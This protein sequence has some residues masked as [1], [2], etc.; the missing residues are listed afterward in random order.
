MTKALH[1][2][3]VLELGSLIGGPFCG[4]LMAEFGAEVIKVEDPETG[5]PA[6]QLGAALDDTSTLFAAMARNKRCIT[7]DLRRSEGQA[8]L[9]RLAS[10]CDVVLE[11]FRVGTLRAWNIDYAALSAVNPRLVMAHVSG[12]GQDGPYRNR[13]AFDRIATAFAG[14]DW[15]TGFPENPPTRPGGAL[16]DCVAALFCT[17]GVMFALHHRD[18]IS[19]RGQEVDLALYEGI[20]RLNLGVE[21]FGLNGTIPQRS[22]NANPGIAPAETFRTRDDNWLVVNAGTDSTWKR[23]AQLMGR[24]DLIDDP[25]FKSARQR[26]Q[27][28]AELH[29]IVGQWVAERDLEASLDVLER[30]QVPAG[31]INSIADVVRDPHV[32]ARQNV[33]EA[34]LDSGRKFLTTGVIP[35]LSESPGSVDFVAPKLGAHNEEVYGGLLGLSGAELRSLK[36]S[37]II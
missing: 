26:A 13:L 37:G 11:N 28:Q 12:F 16:A 30:E 35:K 6:R 1:G 15:I 34:V 17:I 5:D 8:L 36:E 25:R 2:L 3:R 19:G 27:N 33:I 9:K 22:G 29:R 32:Q 21:A 7:L 23:L 18:A 24:A 20:F 14:Q 10:N 31:K 4:T